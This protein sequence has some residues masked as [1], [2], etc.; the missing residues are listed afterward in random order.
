MIP[1][2]LGMTPWTTTQSGTISLVWVESARTPLG[3]IPPPLSP[4]RRDCLG[5]GEVGQI[6]LL[7]PP[8]LKPGTMETPT[9]PGGYDDLGA[10]GGSDF[11]LGHQRGL[12]LGGRKGQVFRG[13]GDPRVG[14]QP[15]R[16]LWGKSQSWSRK[17][18]PGRRGS[19]RPRER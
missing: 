14:L 15:Q 17:S 8:H 19:G 3:R 13:A 10:T 12:G 5:P 2:P 7:T 4:S 6:R 9:S 1:P 16:D 18:P 11:K